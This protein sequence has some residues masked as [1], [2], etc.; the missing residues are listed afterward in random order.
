[1]A[2]SIYF[3]KT[4][5][6]HKEI[7]AYF[8]INGKHQLT[9]MHIINHP[10]CIPLLTVSLEHGHYVVNE[11]TCKKLNLVKSDGYLMQLVQLETTIDKLELMRG[12]YFYEYTPTGLGC[13]Q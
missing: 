3:C 1:M 11:M 6:G 12:D 8:L 2:M 7:Y 9:S 4:R 10:I 5:W 13:E